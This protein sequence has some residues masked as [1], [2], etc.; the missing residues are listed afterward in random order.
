M[1]DECVAIKVS[2]L[3]VAALI[4][5]MRALPDYGVVGEGW[6]ELTEICRSVFDGLPALAVKP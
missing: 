4:D 3:Q 2:P 6:S 1:S 5:V